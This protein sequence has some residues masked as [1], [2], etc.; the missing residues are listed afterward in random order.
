M[1][2]N[3]G[4]AALTALLLSV[5]AKAAIAASPTPYGTAPAYGCGPAN[6]QTTATTCVY[7]GGSSLAKNV[8]AALPGYN[9]LVNTGGEMT[10]Y[11][12]TTNGAAGFYYESAGSGAGKSAFLNNDPSLWGN[13]DAANAFTVHFGASDAAVGKTG[14]LLSPFVGGNGKSVPMKYDAGSKIGQ[15]APGGAFIQ[16]PMFAT[17][18]TV[19]V[20]HPQM[21]AN[22]SLTLTKND[23][24]GIFSGLYTNW[25]Q[26]SVYS[27]AATP[28]AGKVGKGTINVY[29]RADNGGSGTTALFTN[30]LA[31]VCTTTGTGTNSAIKFSSTTKFASLFGA[32]APSGSTALWTMPA[33]KFA[34]QTGVKG[35][36][37][38]ANGMA[39]GETS[40]IGYLSPDFTAIAATP[41]AAPTGKNSYKTL[42]VT[43]VTNANDGAA[44]LPDLASTGTAL[45][46]PGASASNVTPPSGND[47]YDQTKWV[48]IIPNPSKGY[49]IVGFTNLV[50]AQCYDTTKQAGANLINFLGRHYAGNYDNLLNNNGFVTLKSAGLT[51]FVTAIQTTLLA[52]T[53]AKKLFLAMNNGTGCKGVVGR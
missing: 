10:Q 14:E 32:T 40:G 7:G 27:S 34:A 25:N 29:W 41:A 4:R 28:P 8:Y 3:L 22:G 24:C 52:D 46:N 50:V 1:S 13:G 18:I 51:S 48:P 43:K 44:Y 36:D 19:P 35:S 16:L 2:R 26:T 17:P 53:G 42:F 15:L 11:A 37:G 6:S 23:L 49:P 5:A 33:G 9:G 45:L 20:A 39:N 30:Y 21:K 12:Q 31:S 38:V 47:A